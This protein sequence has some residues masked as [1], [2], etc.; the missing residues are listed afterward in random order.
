MSA[1]TVKLGFN[2]QNYPRM[3]LLIV[4]VALLER[5]IKQ[6]K[7]CDDHLVFCKLGGRGAMFEG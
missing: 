3:H 1:E 5:C 7:V 4:I 2:T 6:G